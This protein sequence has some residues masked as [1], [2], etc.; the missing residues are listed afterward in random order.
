MVS[1]AT[2]ASA[3]LIKNN[4]RENK[5][6]IRRTSNN[7]GGYFEPK[8]DISCVINLEKRI[9]KLNKKIEEDKEKQLY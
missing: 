8:L 9:D 6:K 4:Q 2:M 7:D 1:I 5:I 3:A